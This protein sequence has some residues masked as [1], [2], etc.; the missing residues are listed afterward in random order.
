MG[1]GAGHDGGRVVFAGIPAQMLADRTTL[2]SQDDVGKGVV[3][4]VVEQ[5][6]DDALE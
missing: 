6:N 4:P 5:E 3:E 1:P 2:T